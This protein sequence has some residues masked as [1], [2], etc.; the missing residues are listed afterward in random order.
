MSLPCNKSRFLFCFRRHS[1]AAALSLPGALF[2]QANLTWDADAV[3]SGAQDGAGTWNTI[4]TNWWDGAANTSFTAG[5]NVTF[6]SPAA[7]ATI[8]VVTGGVTAGSLTFNTVGTSSYTFTGA[9]ITAGALTKNG[10]NGVRFDNANSFSS[11]TVNAG[12][13]SQADGALRLGNAN[14]LGTA[15]ITFNNTAS[16]TGLFFLTGFGNA[17]TFSNNITFSSAT[18]AGLQTRLL[19]TSNTAGGPQTVTFSGLL[20]GGV[21]SSKIRTDGTAGSGQSVVRLTNSGNTVTLSEWE[22]WRGALEI[23]SDGALG[24]VNNAIRLNVGATGDPLGTGLRFGA[25]NIVLPATRSIFVSDRTNIQTFNFTGSR[26]DGPITFSNSIVKKGASTLTLNGSA[27]GTGGVRVDEGTLR[28]GNGG[29]TGALGSGAISLPAAGGTFAV[30]RSD[31]VTLSNAISGIGSITQAGTGTT[32]LSAASAHTGTVNVNS[33]TLAFTGTGSSAGNVV[34]QPGGVLDVTGLSSAYAIPTGKSLSG[35][36]SSA[37]GTDVNGDVDTAG[38]ILQ[39]MPGSGTGT[40]TVNGDLLVDGF[41]FPA[42]AISFDL[43]DNP[44]ATNDR[45]VVTGDLDLTV[46]ANIGINRL[47]GQLGSGTYTLIEAGSITGDV[48]NLTFVGL[49]T[50]GSSRQTFT[51]SITAVPNSLTLAV[52]GSAASLVWTGATNLEWSTDAADENW[53]N[54]TA[55][56]S[57]DRFFNADQV[58]FNDISGT[59]VQ[60]LDLSTS[61][62]PASIVV[63]NTAAGTAYGFG[64]SGVITGSTGLTKSGDGLLAITGTSHD[65]NGPVNLNGGTVEVA[66]LEDSTF[67]SSLGAGSSISIDN[68]RLVVTSATDVF[69][70]RTL[71]IGSNGARLDTLTTGVES[72]YTGAISAAGALTVGGNGK[73]ALSGTGSLVGATTILS[74]ATLAATSSAVLGSGAVVNDGTLEMRLATNATLNNAVSGSGGLLKTGLGNLTAS[75][76]AGFSS[77]PIVI[78]D[79]AV[80][81]NL[82]SGSTVTLPGDITLPSGTF[83]PQLSVL[84]ILNP[85]APT[86]LILSGK[87]TGGNPAQILRLCDS[88]VV[89]NHNGVLVLQNAANDFQG[90]IEMWRGTLAFTS[91]AALGNADNDISHSTENLNGALRFDADN[92]TLNAGRS[93]TLYTNTQPMPINTQAFTG[94]IAGNFAGVGNLVKQGTGTLILTGTNNATGITTVSAGTLRVDGTFATGGGTVTVQTGGTLGGSGT[95]N[96]AVAVNTG[97]AIAPGTTVG[98]LTTAAATI[99]GNYQCDISGASSDAIAATDITLAAGSGL[100]VNEIAAGT[101]FPY[102]IA[103]YSGTLTGTFGTVTPGYAVDYATPGQIKLV[104]QAGYESWI[105]SKGL[106][107]GDADFDA[108]PDNDGIENGIEFVL[109]TEPNPANPGGNSTADLPSFVQDGTDWVFTFRRQ[110]LALSVNPRAEF[111][112]DLLATWTT[113]TDPG[114]ATITV[115]PDHYA[116]GIDRVEVRLPQTLASGGRLFARLAADAP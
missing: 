105:A 97:G 85:S 64:G 90:T 65:F 79:G 48:S 19:L 36:R 41:G 39:I 49:P 80:N 37:P 68:A 59:P 43:T 17:T 108:D 78:Q 10:T 112:T 86:T 114:N 102:V 20:S 23:T 89:G 69:S 66:K 110:Q 53:N 100:V 42:N 87:L 76:S 1:I 30:D 8:N 18:T 11:V 111:D 45:I 70:N 84:N 34:I 83:A 60:N 24:N 54:L 72:L 67:V 95:I 113:A 55:P 16:L 21:A 98:T 9:S 5:A 101:A 88:Q 74:G 22:I 15:P 91:D 25:D 29:T 96:R 106:T 40:L 27:S 115:T 4:N 61:V 82:T 71:N 44:A 7:A 62:N 56:D 2:A 75:L 38:G 73:V 12:A 50:P 6:G 52:S 14:A 63:N 35:G 81:F 109:G 94:T 92:I 103:T 107:G 77:G 33:G 47:N 104:E 13:N 28:L 26:I 93:I 58:A 32:T 116:A 57:Q 51:P 3:T 46:A 99:T 31:A